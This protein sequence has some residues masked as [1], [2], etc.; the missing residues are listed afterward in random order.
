MR[1]KKD[2]RS[3]GRRR[4]HSPPGGRLSAPVGSA[5]EEKWGDSQVGGRSEEPIRTM[6]GAQSRRAA[7]PARIKA[8]GR[9]AAPMRATDARRQRL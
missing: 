1:G 3:A 7:R 5:P 2:E 6:D 4:L 9:R 8:A